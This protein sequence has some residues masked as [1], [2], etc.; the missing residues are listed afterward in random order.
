MGLITFT[1][2]L[3]TKNDEEYRRPR[4]RNIFLPPNRHRIWWFFITIT[5]QWVLHW[6][7]SDGCS[8]T[9]FPLHLPGCIRYRSKIIKQKNQNF[10]IH[11]KFPSLIQ[12]YTYTY[13]CMY[14]CM[15]DV[16]M[17]DKQ[18]GRNS[19]A[20]F[21]IFACYITHIQ[22]STYI[23]CTHIN[24]KN[25]IITLDGVGFKP[26]RWSGRIAFIWS[27]HLVLASCNDDNF[28]LGIP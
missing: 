4:L 18:W 21:W 19:R 16:N 13:I 8:H 12:I 26:R 14:V 20:M 22:I 1:N 2:G 24:H 11:V 3:K 15:Y 5:P 25:L 27:R 28:S 7:T 10:Y 23:T 17:L 6:A 9:I